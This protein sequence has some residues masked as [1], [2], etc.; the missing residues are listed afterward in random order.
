MKRRL[1]FIS[2]D[3]T[4]TG[5]PILLLRLAKEVSKANE[6]EVLFLLLDGGSLIEHFQTNGTTYLWNT[7]PS[8]Y[9][10][11]RAIER[12][13]AKFHFTR[14]TRQG[15]NQKNI[16]SL[17]PTVDFI[18]ANTV[19]S[20]RLVKEFPRNLTNVIF[21]IHELKVVTEMFSDRNTMKF[22]NDISFRVLAPCEYLKDFLINH[23]GFDRSKIKILS[24]FIPK[25]QKHQEIS[26]NG[27]SET[28]NFLVGACGSL[29]ARKGYDIFVSIV[30]TVIRERKV[31]G[32]HFLWLGADPNSI[33]YKIFSDDLH[34]CGLAQH[35]TIV[36]SRDNINEY[37][38]KLKVFL[39]PSR[40]DAYPLV[41]LEAAM[42]AIPTIC[43]KDSGGIPEFIGNDAGIVVDYLDIQA[44][45]TSI[46]TLKDDEQTRTKLGTRAREKV[47]YYS[48]ATNI[49]REFVTC[50]E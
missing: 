26:I 49:L 9:F 12:V 5:A 44:F 39:L 36:T 14:F 45:S 28:N 46:L 6:F 24:Y 10:V 19:I 21:Y 33:E 32:I 38:K 29:T 1:L 7:P 48:D 3:A 43:F 11:I 17:I 41:V 35:V 34:K 20:A 15:K 30:Q 4:L 23:Y 22:I 31:C 47:A 16:L 42:F 13:L 18:I 50:L 25:E 8:R 27:L 2:H 40:E 37:I